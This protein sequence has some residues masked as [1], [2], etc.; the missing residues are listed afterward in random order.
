M[1]LSFKKD[2]PFISV[3]SDL[4]LLLSE[5]VDKLSIDIKN[6]QSISLVDDTRKFNNWNKIE[7][8]DTSNYLKFERYDSTLLNK[9]RVPLPWKY[10]DDQRD[11]SVK[12]FYNGKLMTPSKDYVI[13]TEVDSSNI[14]SGYIIDFGPYI[15]NNSITYV[16]G[17]LSVFRTTTNLPI[18][19]AAVDLMVERHDKTIIGSGQQN[20]AL[21]WGSITDKDMYI[22]VFVNGELFIE[23]N[24]A[25]PGT[26]TY[27]LYN[28]YLLFARPI[29]GNLSIIR[30]YRL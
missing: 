18:N 21:P 22:E 9:T 3:L 27:K 10:Y 1:L 16:N 14:S 28:T 2:R 24:T 20:H 30:H 7:S 29:A 12:V 13:R 23:D 15:A 4:E 19:V 26:N 11:L 17:T 5:T 6:L 8:V 25:D